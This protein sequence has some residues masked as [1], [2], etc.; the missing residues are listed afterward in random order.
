M[1][2]LSSVQKASCEE[3]LPNVSNYINSNEIFPVSHWQENSPKELPSNRPEICCIIE[4]SPGAR[5]MKS[6]G[7]IVKKKRYSPPRDIPQDIIIKANGR[8]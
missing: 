2:D 3:L 6:K 5:Q 1:I 8:M 7:V 4:A